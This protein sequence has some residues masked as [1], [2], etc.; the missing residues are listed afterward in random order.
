[1]EQSLSNVQPP[2]RNGKTIVYLKKRTP[3]EITVYEEGF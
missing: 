1:M 2:E 3:A